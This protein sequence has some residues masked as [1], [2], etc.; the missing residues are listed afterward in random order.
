MSE[1]TAPDHAL[2]ARASP[3]LPGTRD[4]AAAKRVGPQLACPLFFAAGLLLHTL[5]TSQDAP[6]T[7]KLLLALLGITL[8]FGPTVPFL[9]GGAW[10]AFKGREHLQRDRWLKA[11]GQVVVGEITD[12]WT[13]VH[14]GLRCYVAY[15]FEA[16]APDGTQQ[17]FSTC[18]I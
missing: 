3:T 11:E 16:R 7:L 6:L 12:R 13:Q 9:A 10:L 18:G 14:K 5:T 1:N 15:R 2:R 8:S 4:H 17:T